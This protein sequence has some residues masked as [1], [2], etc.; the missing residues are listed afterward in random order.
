MLET[1]KAEANQSHRPDEGH[2]QSNSTKQ[3]L[4]IVILGADG[5][6][7]HREGHPHELHIYSE[8]DK[9]DH[10][11]RVKPQATVSDIVARFYQHT[12]AS[13]TPL[14][15]FKCESNG[16]DVSV[17]PSLMLKQLAREIDCSD[18]TWIF[19]NE[20]IRISVAGRDLTVTERELCFEGVV[21][22]RF[23]VY[24]TSDQIS[25]TVTYRNADENQADGELVN[26]QCVRVK[27]G[28][29]FHVKRTNRS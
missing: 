17:F 6:D 3:D 22:L 23:G 28:T 11:F 29:R 1:N 15:R 8:V 21:K 19:T 10:A 16:R 25:Y 2:D 24:E 13:P 5:H 20:P 12:G 26:G 9:I 14:D 7:R 27:D 18:D 4:V